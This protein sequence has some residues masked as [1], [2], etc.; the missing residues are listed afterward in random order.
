MLFIL[1]SL[2]AYLH[3]S[4]RRIKSEIN[5]ATLEIFHPDSLT[6]L[7]HKAVSFLQNGSPK[8]NNSV[9]NP[10]SFHN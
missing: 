8:T 9:S 1:L 3:E 5:S 4:E 7:G 10:L 2:F 6:V